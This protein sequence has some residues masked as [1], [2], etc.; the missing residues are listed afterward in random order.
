M[1]RKRSAGRPSTSR[2]TPRT[3]GVAPSWASSEA[4]RRRMQRQRTRDTGPEM[5]VRRLLHKSG[6]RYRVD[7]APLAGL[8]RRADIVFGSARVAVFIDGCFWHGCPEHGMRA[9]HV[10][11]SYWSAKV[12]RNQA[13]DESTD[14]YLKAAGW[15]VIRVWEHEEPAAVAAFIAETVARRRPQS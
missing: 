4:V 15:D 5:A 9:T 1:T 7:I 6:L 2:R 10:N 11:S 12:V 13:R 8:R 14:E 3:D